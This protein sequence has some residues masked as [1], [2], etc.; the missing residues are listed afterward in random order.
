M[1]V[2]IPELQAEIVRII[3]DLGYQVYDGVPIT[4][5]GYPFVAVDNDYSL[6]EDNKSHYRFNIQYPIYLWTNSSNSIEIKN[7][8]KEIYDS[9]VNQEESII[10]TDYTVNEVVFDEQR[11]DRVFDETEVLT[12]VTLILAIRI[13]DDNCIRG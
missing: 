11:T 12:Q 10:L 8:A 6:N 9:L 5:V 7:M 3:G 13:S 4:K 2:P 1:G